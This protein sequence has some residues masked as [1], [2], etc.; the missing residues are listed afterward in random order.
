[1]VKGNS[2]VNPR[3]STQLRR[4]LAGD[5]GRMASAGI[6]RTACHTAR[7]A[8]VIAAARLI[9]KA[10]TIVRASGRKMNSGNR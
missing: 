2:H 6:N 9:I 1:M 3:T 5:G 4:Y 7:P 10:S 8:P